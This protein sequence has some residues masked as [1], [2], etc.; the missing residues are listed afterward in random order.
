M[1][2]AY[3]TLVKKDIQLILEKVIYASILHKKDLQVKL[4]TYAKMI[5]KILDGLNLLENKEIVILFLNGKVIML[6]HNAQINK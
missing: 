4:T 2:L 3:Q 1:S 6:V 5:L